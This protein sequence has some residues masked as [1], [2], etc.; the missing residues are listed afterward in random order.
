[1]R[2]RLDLLVFTQ[3]IRVIL[4]QRITRLSVRTLVVIQPQHS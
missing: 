4:A 3:A 2:R 1:L